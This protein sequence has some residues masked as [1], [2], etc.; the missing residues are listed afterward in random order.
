MGL[1][2]FFGSA[3]FRV[4]LRPLLTSLGVAFRLMS[5]GEA[6]GLLDFGV[7]AGLGGVLE[8][9][10]VNL[11]LSAAVKDFALTLPKE[12]KKYGSM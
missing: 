11:V 7:P 1:S 2:L 8:G 4:P 12:L 6:A 5:F 10:G 3:V 9:P